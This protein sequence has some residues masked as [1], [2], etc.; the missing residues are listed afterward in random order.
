M[1]VKK[2]TDEVLQVPVTLVGYNYIVEA[3]EIVLDTQ[4]FRFYPKLSEI[5]DKSVR[6]LEKAIRT[7]KYKSLTYMEESVHTALGI[8]EPIISNTDYIRLAA[9]LY[10]EAYE[11][12]EE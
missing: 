2:Y 1:T 9:Q 6:Y 8:T 12:K 4:D 3:I 5:T 11:N 7:A 10:K